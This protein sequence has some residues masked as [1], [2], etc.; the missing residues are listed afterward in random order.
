MVALAVG[1]GAPAVRHFAACSRPRQVP[2]QLGLMRMRQLSS[3]A[4]PR[5]ITAARANRTPE[6]KPSTTEEDVTSKWGLEAG[7]WKVH[8]DSQLI[9]WLCV[10]CL[11]IQATYFATC[12]YPTGIGCA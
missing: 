9:T 10:P 12:I 8:I 5:R 2:R 11:S 7:L 3:A 4:A 1:Y 6:G